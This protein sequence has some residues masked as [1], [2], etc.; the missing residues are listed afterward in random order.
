MQPYRMPYQKC[1]HCEHPVDTG[2]C[3]TNE[4]HQPAAGDLSVCAY[5]AGYT[6]YGEGG[7][8]TKITEEQFKELPFP[9]KIALGAARNAVRDRQAEVRRQ[10]T[11]Q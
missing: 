8:L 6:V 3:V 5:C 4:K 9:V 2:T 7:Y 10:A 11:L 1:P